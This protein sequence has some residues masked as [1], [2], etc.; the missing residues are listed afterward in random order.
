MQILL[1]KFWYCPFCYCWCSWLS[2]RFRFWC[3]WLSCAVPASILIL[4]LVPLLL[5]LLLIWS[6]DLLSIQVLLL[7]LSIMHLLV[8][9][10]KHWSYCITFVYAHNSSQ[11]PR[12][13]GGYENV[14]TRDIH[15]NQ[16]G[17]EQHWLK[18]LDKYVR[19]LQE[20]VFTGYFHSVGRKSITQPECKCGHK[21]N[22]N[23]SPNL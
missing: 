2:C 14:P 12:L 13:D 19:P 15:M 9:L 20:K 23:M 6:I 11:D 17:Y 8:T 16:I 3:C 4:I 10:L 18:F 21:W 22:L 5:L 7:L 1:I